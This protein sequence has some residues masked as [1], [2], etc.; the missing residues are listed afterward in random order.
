MLRIFSSL[1]STSEPV[2]SVCIANFNGVNV[3]ADC[4]DSVLNQ[5]GDVSFE[6][7]IHDDASTDGSVAWIRDKY[8]N[9][10]LLAANHNAG[11]CIANN[12]M[13]AHA[14]GEF[15]L[16]LNNDAALHADALQTL[17]DAARSSQASTGMTGIFTLPQY[18][19]SSG[20]LVDRGCLLDPFY[21]PVP[22]VDPERVDVAYVIGACMFM[23]RA[24]WNDLG[25]LPEWMESIA[26]DMYICCAARLQGLGVHAIPASGYKHQQ[27]ASFG[28]N[29][30]TSGRL[31]STYRRR[32][33][34]ERNKTA[35]M[36]ICTP[37][38]WIWCWLAVHG[39]FLIMEG[40]ALT[41]AKRDFKIWRNIYFKALKEIMR[42]W[43]GWHQ[44]R[45]A[46]QGARKI[47]LRDYL[48]VMVPIPRKMM[49]LFKH[50]I[51]SFR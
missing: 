2:C 15:V 25:G 24:L 13:V 20:Q 47:G 7:I 17:V 29:R 8:P 31:S 21:N 49:L 34:S 22:N 36:L 9:V 42:E 43:R 3:L 10:D 26:E 23:P 48:R 40:A 5:E 16:L 35:V 41:L 32:A 50:G 14:R 1:K 6:I 33:L 30:V 4:I 44:R 38:G 37:S 18:D 12:R 51:P 28:G 19:W 45:L 27:G 46:I 39:L 11:F